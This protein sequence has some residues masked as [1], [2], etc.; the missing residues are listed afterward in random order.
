MIL[1][2]SFF[3]CDDKISSYCLI[4]QK[5]IL[6]SSFINLII[7][8]NKNIQNIILLFLSDSY[9]NIS[10][11]SFFCLINKGLFTFMFNPPNFIILNSVLSLINFSLSLFSFTSSS[12]FSSIKV[13]EKI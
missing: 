5:Y 3:V 10:F 12:F 6:E 13:S 4:K 9:W 11:F 1:N 8:S 7:I 2:N